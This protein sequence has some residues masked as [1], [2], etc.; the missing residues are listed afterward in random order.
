MKT[1]VT[2]CM[3]ALA[4]NSYAKDRIVSVGGNVTEIIYQ[5]DKQGQLVGTDTTSNYPAAASKT[6]KIGYARALSAEGILSLNPSVVFLT[7][8]AGPAVVLKQLKEAGVNIVTLPTEYSVEG[9]TAKVEAV[10][11]YLNA[12]QQ[13]KVIID[14]IKR[15]VEQAKKIIAKKDKAP[16]I[17]FIL[18]RRSGNLL[19]SGRDTQADGMIRLVGGVNPMQE[20]TSYK[21][22]TPEQIA[23]VMPDVIL[24]MNRHGDAGKSKVVEELRKHPV[25]KLTPAVQNNKIISM[26]GSYLLG[27]GPRVGKA[28]KELAEQLYE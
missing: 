21:P 7:K 8:E 18:S 28:L 6:E 26:N 11:D 2:L 13:G 23:E 17:L 12:K 3:L 9:A 22:L 5:L 16:K 10:S 24:L 1:L 19:V 4:F 20:F 15:D 14:E 27:F 25:L